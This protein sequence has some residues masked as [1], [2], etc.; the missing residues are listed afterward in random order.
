MCQVCLAGA[1]TS[2]HTTAVLV[3][4]VGSTPEDVDTLRVTHSF[5]MFTSR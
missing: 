5:S 2:T 4:G 1:R 3:K